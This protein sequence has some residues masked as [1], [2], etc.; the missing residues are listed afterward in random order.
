M[1]IYEYRTAVIADRVEVNILCVC[2]YGWHHIIRPLDGG[3]SEFQ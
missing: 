2:N 3:G 1:P